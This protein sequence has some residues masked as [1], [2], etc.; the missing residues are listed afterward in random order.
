VSTVSWFDAIAVLG[1]HGLDLPTEA[2]W[3]YACRAGTSTPWATGADSA[4]LAGFANVR[5]PQLET[6]LLTEKAPIGSF[7]PNAFGIHDQ[8]G[9]L[10]EWCRDGYT[11]AADYS[12]TPD[13]S[14]GEHV[15]SSATLR[16]FRGGCYRDEANLAR[17]AF[18]LGKDPNS[19]VPT[20]GIRARRDLM[21]D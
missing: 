6:M 19:R 15:V 18:R 8:H 12:V 3:E 5:I 17:S 20:I 16:A 9:N 13:E 1:R 11:G 21:P 14:T 10:F 4:S 7:R 2:Q